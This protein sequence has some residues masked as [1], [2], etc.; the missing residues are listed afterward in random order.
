MVVSLRGKAYFVKVSNQ[1]RLPCL[2]YFLEKHRFNYFENCQQTQQEFFPC[3]IFFFK[4][5][6]CNYLVIIV[7]LIFD[8][9]SPNLKTPNTQTNNCL[10]LKAYFR[11]EWITILSS[12][13]QQY[14][15]CLHSPENQNWVPI[16]HFDKLLTFWQAFSLCYSRVFSKSL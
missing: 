5:V 8:K 6:F 14:T 4:L 1:R 15:L 10:N 7:V 12:Y 3:H 11:Y 13:K 9:S 2:Y 16:P